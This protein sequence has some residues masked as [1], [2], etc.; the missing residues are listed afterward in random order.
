MKKQFYIFLILFLFFSTLVG[1]A[2]QSEISNNSIPNETIDKQITETTSLMNSDGSK[3]EHYEKILLQL[4]ARSERLNYENGILRS[5]NLLMRVYYEQGKYKMV[6][7]LGSELKSKINKYNSTPK[8]IISNIY[9]RNALSLS[10]LGLDDAGMRDFKKAIGYAKEIEKEGSRLYNLSLCYENM[11]VIYNNEHF[12]GNTKYRDSIRHYLNK[13]LDMATGIH[14]N[15]KEI[16]RKLKYSQILFIDIRLGIFFL[17]QSD[18]KGS[19]EKAEKY[20]L[21]ALRIYEAEKHDI[22]PGYKVILM[23]QLSWLYMEK[24]EPEKSIEYANRAL[25]LEKV[26]RDPHDRIESYEF[27][28]DSYLR[29]G[30]N[31]KSRYYMK[32]YSHLKDSLAYVQKNNADTI[33]KKLVTQVDDEYI[34]KRKK[35]LAFIFISTLIVILVIVLL[36]KRK[37]K[38]IH[39]KYE[40]MIEK[41]KNDEI[42][43]KIKSSASQTSNTITS[44]TEEKLLSDLEDFEGSELFLKKDITLRFLSDQFGSNTKYL[45]EIINKNKSQNFNNY[46]NQLRVNYIV[47]KLYNEPKYREYKISYLAEACGFASPQVF[48]TAFKRVYRVT[49]FYFIQNLKKDAPL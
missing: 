42:G 17:E 20:L 7:E 49:P 27:L 4:K 33:M 19:I 5:G 1:I 9:R 34:E 47:H 18:V 36:W 44:E 16:T 21:D 39:R 29:L 37:N 46:I 12:N 26:N 2:Y 13:G 8:H 10:S 28:T 22:L 48:A 24:K 30:E 32:E 11:T 41:L 15:D 35:M 40:Q 31:E 6:V 38:H 14:D 3:I 25:Q 23:N 45:S 43:K